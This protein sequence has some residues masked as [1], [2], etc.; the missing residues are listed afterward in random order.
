MIFAQQHYL[1]ALLLCSTTTTT[2]LLTLP[3]LHLA[4]YR[5]TLG[6]QQLILDNNS[7]VGPLPPNLGHLRNLNRIS[8]RKT[9][10]SCV[11]LSIYT[12]AHSHNSTNSS[13]GSNSSASQYN[14][15]NSSS[16][17]DDAEYLRLD[18]NYR[19]SESELLPCFLTFSEHA[20]PRTDA[21]NMACPAVERLP[22]GSAVEAC[23]GSA[24]WQLGEFASA[25]AVTQTAEQSWE[26]DPAVYQY[27]S[28]KC[29]KVMLTVQ[30]VHQGQ[31]CAARYSISCC[32]QGKLVP[33]SRV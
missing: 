24:P 23:A 28:C 22:H 5:L 8:L 3:A 13:T 17:D 26:L 6:L 20:V 30:Y 16:S 19:C 14:G 12:S 18:S 10:I 9:N 11:P 1:F 27:R 4:L 21:T 32:E 15:T 25:V 2:K 29:L 31:Q 7:F 33:P